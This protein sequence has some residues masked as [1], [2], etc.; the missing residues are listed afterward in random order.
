VVDSTP[1]E[2][3]RSRETA[4]RSDLAGWAEYGYCAS[5]SRYFWGLRL[6]LVCTLHGLPIGWARTGAKADERRTLH[7]ILTCTTYLT[8]TYVSSPTTLIG[9]KNYHG[10][11]FETELADAGITLLRPQRKGEKPRSI[12][13]VTATGGGYRRSIKPDLMATGGRAFYLGGASPQEAIAFRSVSPLGPGLKVASPA[14]NKETQVTGTSFAA[15]MVSR[16]A[17]RLHDLVGDITVGTPISRRQ[18][19]AATKAL[20]VHGT[21]W[22]PDPAYDPLPPE[23]AI[24]N[25]VIARDYADG[26][27]GNEA[28]ILY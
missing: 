14:V 2:C 3:D 6:H 17:A 27:S 4:K 1:V 11:V 16:Q 10:R 19:A 22:P 26:C 21:V 25:G 7:D 20:L 8:E 9:D 18:R 24:G 23:I 12:S 13:P 15:A 5:H 28:V